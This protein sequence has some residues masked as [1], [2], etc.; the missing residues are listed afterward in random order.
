MESTSPGGKG[1]ILIGG[2]VN[3]Y[4]EKDDTPLMKAA[5]KGHL[6][7]VDLLISKGANIN[8]ATILGTA[9]IGAAGGGHKEVV[10]ILLHRGA[11]VNFSNNS[12]QT[13]LHLAASSGH[14]EVVTILLNACTKVFLH[15][16]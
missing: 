5:G 10:K 8:Y 9:L 4:D 14:T 3:Y 16:F 1:V 2:L 7:M 11:G 12:G 6:E 13:A 15:H